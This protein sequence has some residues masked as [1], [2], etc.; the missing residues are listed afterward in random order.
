MFW[1]I[2]LSLPQFSPP[3]LRTANLLFIVVSPSRPFARNFRSQ[4]EISR[5]HSQKHLH[6]PANF[7]TTLSSQ[8][9]FEIWWLNFASESSARVTIRIRIRSHIAATV[10]HSAAIQMGGVLQY[11]W[12]AHCDTNGKSSGSLSLSSEHKGTKSTAVQNFGC[13]EA[14]P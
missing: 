8:L 4:D 3:P 12:E 13:S 5:F 1:T 6:S 7:F 2:C 9:L 11:K 10:V 14:Q